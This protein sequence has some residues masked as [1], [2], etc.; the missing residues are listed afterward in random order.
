MKGVVHARALGASVC[1]TGQPKSGSVV[2]GLSGDYDKLTM[3]VALA[4]VEQESGTAVHLE[5]L[6][7][8]VVFDSATISDVSYR[9]WDIDLA[10]VEKLEINWQ[11]E[12]CGSESAML[13]FGSPVFTP[14]TD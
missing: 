9:H 7:D 1:T 8:G 2:Y 11:E 5:A 13:R 14:T 12:T 4:N 3:I 6:I 10:G